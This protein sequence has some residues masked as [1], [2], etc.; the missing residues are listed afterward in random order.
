MACGRLE[1]SEVAGALKHSDK[2]DRSK[3]RES[4]DKLMKV[5]V[6][7]RL[8]VSTV[9]TSFGSESKPTR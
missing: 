8:S 3:F 4:F 1:S 6:I 9:C 7:E 5:A 2:I